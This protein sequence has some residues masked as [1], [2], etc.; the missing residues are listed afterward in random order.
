M[1]TLFYLAAEE[2][3]QPREEVSRC[4]VGIELESAL[5]LRIRA[6]QVPVEDAFRFAEVAMR[7][8]ILLV[9]RDRL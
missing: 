9:E 2:W 8:S 6:G 7:L 1:E 4:G 3:V 5:Q